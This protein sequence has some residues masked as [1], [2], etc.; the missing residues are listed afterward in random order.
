M[1][2]RT[3]NMIGGDGKEYGPFRLED[4]QE[5]LDQGRANAQ[6]MVRP[7]DSDGEWN[8]LGS[9][10]SIHRRAEQPSYEN[11][12]STSDLKL[13][14]RAA[15][16]GGWSVF[17]ARP[18]L[19][20]GASLLFMLIFAC[21]NLIPMV[22]FFVR[23]CLKGPLLAGIYLLIL[24]LIR[25]RNV[26]IYNFFDGFS[27]RLGVL[28]LVGIVQSAIFIIAVLPGIFLVIISVDSTFGGLDWNNEQE[29]REALISSFVS[30]LLW[31]GIILA[32]A[33]ACTTSLL[34]HFAIPLIADGGM[35]FVQAFRT[36][37]RVS[38]RNFFRLA[39]LMI[40]IVIII[41]ISMIPIGLGLLVAIPFAFA[42]LV[43]AYQQ[44]F[45]GE[46]P[47]P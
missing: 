39:G 27:N 46:E 28:V 3:Y 11:A 26:G 24:K 43:S 32:T 37:V 31:A 38:F 35:N 19:L 36:S 34:T 10:L 40:I 14:I 17:A 45:I 47:A 4:L 23:S 21:T 20:M 1:S 12:I 29:I 6:S 41:I 33:L 13:S 18:G 30:P 15:L 22:G 2:E 7:T 25:M 44:L 9:I 5:Y 8:T 16:G 42:V